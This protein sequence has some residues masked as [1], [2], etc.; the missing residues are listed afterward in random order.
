MTS[1]GPPHNYDT[2]GPDNI[3]GNMDDEEWKNAIGSFE[4]GVWVGRQ[5]ASGLLC[6][7]RLMLKFTIILFGQKIMMTQHMLF[8]SIWLEFRL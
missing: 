6:T 8:L 4:S 1:D 5:K 7:L 3:A 2:Y